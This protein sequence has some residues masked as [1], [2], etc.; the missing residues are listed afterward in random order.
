MANSAAPAGDACREK[1][2]TKLQAKCPGQLEAFVGLLIAAPFRL[3]A[4]V[5]DL[6]YIG[7]YGLK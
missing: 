1:C 4:R 5:T 2:S 7:R 6:R 3:A